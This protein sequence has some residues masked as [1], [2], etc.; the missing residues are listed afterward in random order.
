MKT[1]RFDDALRY[2]KPK[3]DADGNSVHGCMVEIAERFHEIGATHPTIVTNLWRSVYNILRDSD[4]AFWLLWDC[5]R[6]QSKWRAN[7]YSK[8]AANRGCTKQAI[9]QRLESDLAVIALRRPDL[10]VI[11]RE[12]I[13]RG[14]KPRRGGAQ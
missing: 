8:L 13:G 11:V 12:K 7:S 10:A 3:T 14:K 6:P 5:L 1:V 4:T 9:H 2:E